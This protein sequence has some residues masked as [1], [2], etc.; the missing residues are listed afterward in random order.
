MRRG[1]LG[2]GTLFL[3]QAAVAVVAAGSGCSSSSPSGAPASVPAPDGARFPDGDKVGGSC[4][5]D[6]YVTG[7]V[8]YL[9]CDD[10]AW[11]YSATDPG[12]DGFGCLCCETADAGDDAPAASD[13]KTTD[14]DT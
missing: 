10:G 12:C 4:S 1:A 2:I 7:S 11:S 3:S 6:E 5:R 8:G 14:A 9:F 13:A